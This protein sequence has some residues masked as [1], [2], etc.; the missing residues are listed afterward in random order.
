M[1]AAVP[2][3]PVDPLLAWWFAG[4]PTTPVGLKCLLRLAKTVTEQNN[5]RPE[6]DS[7]TGSSDD[8]AVAVKS[9]ECGERPAD[10]VCC[11]CI[12]AQMSSLAAL[13]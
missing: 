1:S 3:Q 8:G 9:Y 13:K 10:S 6:V 2:N 12:D 7:D 4:E 5:L 11:A